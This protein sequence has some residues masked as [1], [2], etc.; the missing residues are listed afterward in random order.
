MS[1]RLAKPCLACGKLYPGDC[2]HNGC[3]NE[4]C[5]CDGCMVMHGETV[6]IVEDEQ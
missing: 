4:D 5:D 2:F 1:V 6:F 3:K